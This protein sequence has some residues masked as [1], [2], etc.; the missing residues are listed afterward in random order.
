MSKEKPQSKKNTKEYLDQ[1]GRK[2]IVKQ[3]TKKA[4]EDLDALV[5]TLTHELKSPAREIELYAEFI[6]EDNR[7]RLLPQSVKDIRSIRDTCQNIIALVC[8]MMDYSRVGFKVIEKKRIDMTLLIRQCFDE[9]VNVQ[10]NHT[11]RLKTEELPELYGD[12]FMIR[13]MMSNIIS[14]S[15]KFTRGRENAEVIVS[16]KLTNGGIEYCIRDNG[17][18]FD[19]K[20]AGNLFEPFQRLQ[21]EGEYEGNGIGLATVKKVVE[22]FGGH[23][24]IEGVLNEGCTVSVWF[25]GKYLYY[26]EESESDKRDSIK[27]GIISDFTGANSLNEQG[28]LAAYKLAA[29][30]INAAG[31]ILG[32]HVELLFRDDCGSTALTASAAEEL[33]RQE[34]VNVLMGSTLSPTRDVMISYANQNKTLYLDTQQTEGGVADHYTF[35]LSA[36]PEQQMSCMIEYLIRKFGKKCYIIASD[37]N[38]GILSAEW[39]KYFVRE[40]GGEVVG[41]EYLDDQIQDFNSVIDRIVQLKTDVLFSLCVYP[42]HDGF[43]QQWS[44]R[45][46]SRIPNATTIDVA[47]KP[48][49]VTLPP[50]MMENTYVMASFLEE[51]DTPSAR[52]FVQKYRS[53]YDRETVLYMGMDV[54][55][56]YSAM[57]IYKL[58]CELAGTTEVEAVISALET[59]N[60]SFEGPGGRIQVRGND[61]HTARQMSCF[62]VDEN[63]QVR[64]VFRTE[65]IHSDYIEKMIESR[66]GMKGGMCTL[67]ANAVPIQY[68]MLL[69]KL[70]P[71]ADNAGGRRYI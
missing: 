5:Y 31:G 3:A 37:Y 32:R 12:L 15:I 64:E 21:N 61:H 40:Y 11:V 16:S 44:R 60:I 35:C 23:V 49:Q 28:K 62:R 24:S 45:G 26:L 47:V 68:N 2:E 1:S 10:N 14:N 6:E 57:Y 18:G 58:A 13:L 25:P 9:Q 8:L 22:R 29:E 50:P 59:G 69:N 19:Q 41:C 36:M 27:V 66:F 4:Y 52:E 56:A 17:I 33:T 20:Y 34:H 46:L 54:E 53:R 63:N 67:G 43:F 48:R 70:T 38:F 55:T 7:G 51:L 30:E 39:A 71:S 42:N 65:P